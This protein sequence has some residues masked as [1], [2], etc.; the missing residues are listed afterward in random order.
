MPVMRL[1]PVKEG[2]RARGKRENGEKGKRKKAKDG[3]RLATPV[4]ATL[5]F[6]ISPFPHFPPFTL[7]LYLSLAW[8]KEVV[9]NFLR[10]DDQEE[11][12]ACQQTE[13]AHEA[14]AR[15]SG[16][17]NSCLS[18]FLPGAPRSE[19]SDSRYHKRQYRHKMYDYLAAVLADPGNE[20]VV[21]LHV[22]P[23]CK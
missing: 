16:V 17:V 10:D 6:T 13:H 1:T 7:S 3:E 20:C 23:P 18:A 4:F 8:M 19:S 22:Q 14:C 21:G 11:H 2:E 12:A 9:G 5:V 15:Q